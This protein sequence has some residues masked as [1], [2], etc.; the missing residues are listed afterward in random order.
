MRYWPDGSLVVVP[1]WAP[2]LVNV[3]TVAPGSGAPVTASVTRP[4]MRPS[5]PAGYTDRVNVRW[6]RCPPVS[7][8]LIVNENAPVPWGVPASRPPGA[9]VRPGGR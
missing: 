8:A 7:V 2:A 5:L 9:S 1:I 6:A 3:V 4:L